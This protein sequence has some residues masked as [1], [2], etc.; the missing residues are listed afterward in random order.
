MEVYR[1]DQMEKGWFVGDFSPAVLHTSDFEIAI[2]RYKSGDSEARHVH[3]VASEITVIAEGQVEMNG[4][5]FE[6][7]SIILIAAGEPAEF[8]AI[9]D[10]LTVVVK[11]P[12]VKGDKFAI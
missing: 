8:R 9:T 6:E 10:A 3:K 4:R 1:L 5:V 2:K 11:Q 12:S 7:N